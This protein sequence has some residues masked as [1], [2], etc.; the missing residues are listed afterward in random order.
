MRLGTHQK[1]AVIEG[2]VEW[3]R[4]IYVEVQVGGAPKIL[5]IVS[6][7][8]KPCNFAPESQQLAHDLYH[9]PRLA[10]KYASIRKSKLRPPCK[11][12]LG[13]S[14]CGKAKQN[15]LTCPCPCLPVPHPVY[16]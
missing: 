10:S 1:L 12:R 13:L 5:I 16:F 2:N 3:E 9:E 8:V 14:A 15:K 7:K 11:F 4:P 6:I